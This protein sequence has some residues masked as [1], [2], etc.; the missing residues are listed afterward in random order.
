MEE[1]KMFSYD[2]L[3][4]PEYQI[5]HYIV[6]NQY[7]PDRNRMKH[8]TIRDLFANVKHQK[9]ITSR[10][11]KKLI[12][13]NFIEQYHGQYLRIVEKQDARYQAYFNSLS[14]AYRKYD[15]YGKLI[16]RKNNDA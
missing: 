11:L 16:R 9:H 3:E 13:D 4:T 12:N 6:F 1:I 8:L 7:N 10:V 2:W 14:K 15:V 5:F